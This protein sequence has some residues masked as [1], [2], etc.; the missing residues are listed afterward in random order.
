MQGAVLTALEIYQVLQ[1]STETFGSF[2]WLVLI[3]IFNYFIPT[4]NKGNKNNNNR[5]P[6]V[7]ASEIGPSQSFSVLKL[8]D[9][10]FHR[11]FIFTWGTITTSI[12][13][14]FNDSAWFAK[15]N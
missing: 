5:I 3:S 10:D 12:T 13:S 11:F 7:A 6:L 4:W 9:L 15:K 2:E 14:I 1:S 8:S